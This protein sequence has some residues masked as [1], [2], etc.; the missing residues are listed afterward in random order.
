MAR[1]AE[2]AL[3]APL[4]E[5][6]HYEVPDELPAQIGHRCLVPVQQRRL[7]GY[8]LSFPEASEFE[9]KPVISLLDE[10]PLFP[11]QMV[12]LFRW[13]SEYYIHPIGLTIKA[14]LPPGL[15]SESRRL[16]R[17]TG[18]V[19]PP[20]SE[21]LAAVLSALS[22]RGQ[23]TVAELCRALGRDV[24]YSLARLRESGHVVF[25][26]FWQRREASRPLT[27]TL[28]R[29]L[30]EADGSVIG[31]RPAVAAMLEF[32]SSRGECPWS[33]VRA[34]FPGA[35]AKRRWLEAAGLIAAREVRLYR[36]PFDDELTEAVTHE[37]N[38]EQEV[39]LRGVREATRAGGFRPLL[40]H[41]VT[42][43][44]KTEVYLRA[45]EEV[46]AR[47]RGVVMLVP[48]IA[49]SGQ[50]EA[51]MRARFG[52]LVA[53]LHS[54][55]SAGQRLDEWE[56]IR[57]GA[58]R[59]VIG[60]RSA[61]FCPMADPGLII[62]D[63]E[64]EG[65]YKQ[66]DG[67]RYHAR[68]VALVRGRM[69]GAVVV[70]GSATPSVQSLHHVREGR[71]GCLTLTRRA[72][73][74]PMPAVEIVDM[75]GEPGMFSARLMEAVDEALAAG[76]QAMLFLNRRGFATYCLCAECGRPIG[77][78]NCQLSLTYHA[79][80]E[81]LR[82]HYCD[83]SLP[84][85]ASCP[86]CGGG[87]IRLLG[88]GSQRVEAEALSV[89]PEARIQR[90]DSD[91]ATTRAALLKA[92]RAI[93]RG[94]VDIIVATQMMAKGHDL[95]R[96]SLV[97]VVLADESLGLPDFRAAERG[98]QLLAQVA[99]RAGRTSPG[100]VII[101]AYDP[102]HYALKAACRHDSF[103]FFEEEAGLRR[104]LG[105]PP[106]CRLARLVISSTSAQAAATASRTVA[107]CAR[108]VFPAEAV[109][110]PAPAPLGKLKGRY[111][112]HLLLK[113][114][115][116]GGLHGRLKALLGEVGGTLPPGVH[117]A[118]DVDPLDML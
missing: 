117:V 14:A 108:R 96:L 58:A 87:R 107:E 7:T 53:L 89:W 4:R 61:V 33:L 67:L 22:E 93:H 105:Y 71:Y 37:L 86:S 112:W 104:E 47:G 75:R 8:I 49:L 100:R 42:G 35:A 19:P 84:A 56:R 92:L 55:L 38:G 109:L 68:D 54:G 60:A 39:A 25:E 111:R 32:I 79:A 99:G 50:N 81:R 40:L 52:E 115:M 5:T 95:P 34:K 1:I 30:P 48:E 98:F 78:P 76:T 18:L 28:V 73:G 116:G 2:V 82:C 72:T 91:T 118:V 10:A 85:P 90:M 97:G 69:A 17:P 44:G 62:V 11:E 101:Q 59:V 26:D 106:Y 74:A 16:V 9:L 57:S 110:G 6:Y 45:A 27:E 21:A 12:S 43:G 113:G 31:R 36:S 46:L 70:L 23:A 15:T 65:A 77:C 63:E 88:M 24:S 13:L 29:A 114:P 102:G 66:D 20:S 3:A 41:G 80:E 94:E 103:A 83:F 64:H 51:L